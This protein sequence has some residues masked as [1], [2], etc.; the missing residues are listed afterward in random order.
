MIKVIENF[1]TE[2]EEAYIMSNIQ[3]ANYSK[4]VGRNSIK[5]YGSGIPYNS[6]IKSKDL[7]TWS[8]FLLKKLTE[9][10]I[11]CNSITINEYHKGQGIGPHID[12]KTS[13]DII[14]VLSLA[15]DAVMELSL[16][17][18]IKTIQ[19]PARSLLIMTEEE[20]WKWNHSILPVKAIRFSIVFRYGI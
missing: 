9:L 15:G 17:K 4:G 12:S 8:D 14:S 2:D 13:G 16:G 18:E 3:G 7:P 10:D 11:K 20:R 5:R 1:I 6:R 19:L